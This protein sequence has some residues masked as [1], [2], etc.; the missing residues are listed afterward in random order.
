MTCRG[1]YAIYAYSRRNN[2]LLDLLLTSFLQP[3]VQIVII[4]NLDYNIMQ[5]RWWGMEE[6]KTTIRGT[7]IALG[8][9][10]AL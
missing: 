9:A 6:V 8:R 4:Y 2:C 7:A 10:H 5:V 1:H 3:K